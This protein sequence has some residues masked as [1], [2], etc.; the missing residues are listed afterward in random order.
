MLSHILFSFI[1]NELALEIAEK[2]IRGVQVSPDLI[3]ILIILFIDDVPIT[4]YSNVL[5][6]F[7]ILFYNVCQ[8]IKDENRCLSKGCIFV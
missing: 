4:A 5:T 3:Q 8:F 2:G 7:S 6:D 1:I